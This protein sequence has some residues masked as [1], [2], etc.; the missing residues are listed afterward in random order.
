MKK[1]QDIPTATELKSLYFDVLNGYTSM[2]LNDKTVFLKHLNVFDSIDTDKEYSQCLERAKSKKL[3]T[4]K[5]KI[6]YLIEEGLWSN[7]K[8]EKVKTLKEYIIGLEETKSKI[9]MEAEVNYVKEQIEIKSQKLK[10]LTME[11]LKLVGV[12]AEKYAEKRSNEYYMRM[13]IYKDKEFKEPYYSEE[14]F[15]DLSDQ[16]LND[17][18]T[19]YS[20]ASR[21]LN[22][23]C[24][25]RLS[26]ASFFTTFYYLCDDNPYTFYGKP[27]YTLTFFQNEL[28]AYARYFKSLAQDA[29][30]KAPTDMQDD[31]DALIEFYEGSKNAQEA[32]DKMNQGKGAQ[33]AGASTVVGASQKDLEKMGYGK[34]Q[35]ISLAAEAKKR[36]GKLTMEDFADIHVQ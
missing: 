34:Q 15:D 31:P 9:F 13:V 7:E 23:Q 27:V 18:F 33:G 24:I 4:E 29:K 36:G 3:P 26:I 19:L 21:F 35:G 16:S 5:E 32:A 20:G 17:V 6:E 25:K 22:N 11:K 28:F 12:T 14:D 1:K 30:V 10:D 2:K 8:E